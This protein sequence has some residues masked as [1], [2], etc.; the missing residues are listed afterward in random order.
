MSRIEDAKQKYSELNMSMIDLFSRLDSSGNNKYL[1]MMCKVVS[2]ILDIKQH[3]HYQQIQSYLKELG[4]NTS[5][6]SIK[7]IAALSAIINAVGTD[8][9]K[10]FK[11]FM[12]CNERGL[13]TN[14]DLNSYA[15]MS[16]VKKSIEE[17][18]E[19][20]LL[21]ELEKTT[22]VIH[23]DEN[24]LVIRP[25]S[26]AASCKYGANTK[27]CTTFNDRSYFLRYWKRGIL[28]YFI[29]KRTN[30]KWALFKSLDPSNPELSWWNV[31][32]KKTEFFDIDFDDYM[33]P[34]IKQLLKS[35]Q[36]NEGLCSPDM[37]V[38]IEKEC[39]KKESEKNRAYQTWSAILDPTSFSPSLHDYQPSPS[40][41]T[42]PSTSNGGNVIVTST[43]NGTVASG[44]PV[45]VGV[46]QLIEVMRV[47][48][49]R[50]NEIKQ[51]RERQ[52][53]FTELDRLIEDELGY[54]EEIT[55]R[56]EPTAY[57]HDG[58]SFRRGETGR[59]GIM[60]L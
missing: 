23:N 6:L 19:K 33:I 24:W 36:T 47:K 40:T 12:T 43:P 39:S 13:I 28:A 16:Q 5:G 4:I 37:R 51:S 48:Q 59:H 34:I 35:P 45:E 58:V 2:N 60:K 15:A 7:E 54:E 8:T 25:L 57:I 52:K 18:D 27:W 55:E 44:N 17:A 41:S 32:D 38:I 3:V 31:T 9:L 30:I 56:N 42:S 22:H 1:D 11:K 53:A 46:D 14:K 49:D 26:Y 10:D 21:K 20:L 29:D 50:L